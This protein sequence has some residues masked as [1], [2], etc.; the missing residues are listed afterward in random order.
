MLFCIEF[1][2]RSYLERISERGSA[3]CYDEYLTLLEMISLFFVRCEVKMSFFQLLEESSILTLYLSEDYRPDHKRMYLELLVTFNKMV[4]RS[5]RY[6][7]QITQKALGDHLVVNGIVDFVWRLLKAQLTRKTM[8]F[9]SCAAF[10]KTVSEQN[11][12]PVIKSIVDIFETLDGRT[13]R[14]DLQEP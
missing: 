10:F 4:S 3:A 7:K 13:R 1:M 9:S 12:E 5:T 14:G 8:L 11:I 2:T 6:D